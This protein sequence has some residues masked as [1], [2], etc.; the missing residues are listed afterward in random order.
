MLKLT[1]AHIIG[2]VIAFLLSIFIIPMVI[3]YSEKYNIVDKPDERKIH[4]GEI[5]KI[6]TFKTF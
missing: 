5:H 1:E 4:T 2:I 6:K 3:Y